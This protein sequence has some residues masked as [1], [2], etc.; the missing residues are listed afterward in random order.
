MGEGSEQAPLSRLSLSRLPTT[1]YGT[2]VPRRVAL[3][4]LESRDGELRARA[5]AS[6][7]SNRTSG[8]P[9]LINIISGGVLLH[10]LVQ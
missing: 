9:A 3:T 10:C 4:P 6:A 8:Y 7:E 2:G 1:P 5:C